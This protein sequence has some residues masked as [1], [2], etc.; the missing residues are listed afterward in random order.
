MKNNWTFKP[1]L[2]KMNWRRNWDH[3]NCGVYLLKHMET[4]TSE[5]SVEW[6]CDLKADNIGQI[7]KLR[8]KYC[9][10]ILLSNTNREAYRIKMAARRR[11]E[12]SN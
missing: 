4:Y 2:I 1:N 6:V 7:R 10:K 8:V 12:E 11:M 3:K 9:A 5:P